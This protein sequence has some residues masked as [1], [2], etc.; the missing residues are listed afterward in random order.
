[1]QMESK[2]PTFN[3]GWNNSFT[4][5]NF[6]LSFFLVGFHG[7]DIYNAT[8]Q[9]GFSSVGGG[10]KSQ[11]VAAI[12]PMK[13]WLD[14][15]TPDNTD[16]NVPRWDGKGTENT[17]MY[18]T[19]FVEIQYLKTYARTGASQT[20]VFMLQYK[21][22]SISQAIPVLIRNQHLATLLFRVLTGVTILTA[23]TTLSV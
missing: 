4:Y 20:C 6:D 12:S 18:S 9:I 22:R 13:D 5:K 21:I 1:M 7:F 15:W 17:N 14:R 11:Q 2:Q 23:V 10:L 19:R 16:T 8:H 3:W